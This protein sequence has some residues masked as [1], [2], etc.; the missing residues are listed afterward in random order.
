MSIRNQTVFAVTV[1][2]MSVAAAL[3]TA[4]PS[5]AAPHCGNAISVI[6]ASCPFAQNVYDAYYSVPEIDAQVQAYSP[7]TGV[8]YTMTC[9]RSGPSV[10]CS[11]GDNAVVSF[12]F[13][14][15]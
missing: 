14:G 6:N 10:T 13:H 4:G 9:V 2:S 11:G 7:V 8:T 3:A 15:A 1:A 5:S 12:P